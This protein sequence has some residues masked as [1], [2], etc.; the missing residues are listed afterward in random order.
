MQAR[1][2]FFAGLSNV[3]AKIFVA[4]ILAGSNA[5]SL[6]K[7]EILSA[8]KDG[9]GTREN[10]AAAGSNLQKSMDSMKNIQC[11]NILIANGNIELVHENVT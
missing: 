8:V 5:P 6:L 10:L 3:N 7:G 1:G 11:D 9:P 2:T 4:R